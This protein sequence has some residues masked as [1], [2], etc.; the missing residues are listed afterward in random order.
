MAIIKTELPAG[1]K[2]AQAQA[3]ICKGGSTK[4]GEIDYTRERHIFIESGRDLIATEGKA[5][6]GEGI[7]NGNGLGGV[8]GPAGRDRVITSLICRGREVAAEAAIGIGAGLQLDSAIRGG[9]A[10]ADQHLLIAQGAAGGASKARQIIQG[11][12]ELNALTGIG[13]LQIS[14]HGG[15]IDRGHRDERRFSN[16]NISL[17]S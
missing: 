9:V 5:A 13:T 16:Y 8:G 15:P 10:Q 1:G 12:S 7:F 2:A 14:R 11:T 4:I 3:E 17:L 6:H